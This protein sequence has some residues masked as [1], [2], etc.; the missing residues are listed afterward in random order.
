MGNC[1]KF[2]TSTL[3]MPR[4]LLK[5]NWKISFEKVGRLSEFIMPFLWHFV[6][7]RSQNPDCWICSLLLCMVVVVGRLINIFS[8]LTSEYPLSSCYLWAI[9]T[10]AAQFYEFIF[11]VC[12]VS[13]SRTTFRNKA[14]KIQRLTYNLKFSRSNLLHFSF[15]HKKK[16]R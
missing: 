15:P 12:V 3:N 10:A 2:L 5:T 7:S 1:T 13:F 4:E 8:T 11:S 6:C 14:I 16:A 9:T